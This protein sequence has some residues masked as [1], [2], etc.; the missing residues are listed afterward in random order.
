MQNT[1]RQLLLITAVS[2]VLVIKGELV[3]EILNYDTETM[4]QF[5]P[6]CN[7]LR[8]TLS[9]KQRVSEADLRRFLKLLQ[10]PQE[11]ICV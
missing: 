10:A 7:L 6:K 8:S 11:N 9:M 1:T 2:I 4:Y 5:E 3:S